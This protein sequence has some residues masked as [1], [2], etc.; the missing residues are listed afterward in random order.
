MHCLFFAWHIHRLINYLTFN[1]FPGACTI[2][3]TSSPSMTTT[4][5]DGRSDT[6]ATPSL[7]RLYQSTSRSSS[8]LSPTTKLN[9]LD[10][11]ALMSLLK[12]SVSIAVV[13]LLKDSVTF[14][15]MSTLHTQ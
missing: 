5:N 3:S 6:V 7:H 11:K 1:V 15:V 8:C 12:G 10:S 2:T 4:T 9:T 13:K 14:K